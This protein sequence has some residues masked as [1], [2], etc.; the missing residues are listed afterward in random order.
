MQKYTPTNRDDIETFHN[1]IK[2]DYNTYDLVNSGTSIM[3]PSALKI[4]SQTALS[5]DRLHPLG[6]F[7]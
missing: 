4:H 5:K 3:H 1:S 7:L 6:V 2:T